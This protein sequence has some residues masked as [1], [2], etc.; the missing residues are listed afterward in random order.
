MLCPCQSNLL[1]QDC[2]QLYHQQQKYPSQADQLMRSR[3]TAYVLKNIDYIVKTTAPSQQALLDYQALKQWADQ[4]KWQ[5]LEIIQHQPNLTKIHSMVEFKAFFAGKDQ[6]E[7]HHEKSLFV[8]ID[9]IWYFVDPTVSLPSMK[10]S[11][12]CGSHKKFK[13]CCGTYL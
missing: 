10:Q 4:T 8:N 2:C 13:H 9:S 3:Y 1:Y 11:C 5:G 6:T 12:L 7:V